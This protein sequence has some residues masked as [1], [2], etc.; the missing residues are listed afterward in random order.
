MNKVLKQLEDN[1]KDLRNMMNTCEKFAMP[2]PPDTMIKLEQIMETLRLVTDL[3]QSNM[4]I[5]NSIFVGV[6]NIQERFEGRHD[7]RFL[8]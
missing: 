1:N 8:F 7:P 4:K 3:S 6:Q 2:V 5:Q